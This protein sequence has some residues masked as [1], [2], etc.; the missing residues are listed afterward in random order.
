MVYFTHSVCINH[1]Q[2]AGIAHLF[3]IHT[4]PDHFVVFLPFLTCLH[5]LTDANTQDR[6]LRICPADQLVLKHLLHSVFLPASD[7]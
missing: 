2:A 7:A 4:T 5:L 3:V 1:W 6:W